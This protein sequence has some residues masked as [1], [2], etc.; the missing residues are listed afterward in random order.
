MTTLIESIATD[1]NDLLELIQAVCDV[2]WHA[3]YRLASSLVLGD[4]VI[5]VFQ[6]R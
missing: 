4:K 1:R 3:G 5:L 2:R 6:P